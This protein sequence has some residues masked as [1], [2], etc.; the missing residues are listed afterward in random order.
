MLLLLTRSSLQWV[1]AKLP[2]RPISVLRETTALGSARSGWTLVW[3]PA[4]ASEDPKPAVF[5]SQGSVR[6]S[7]GQW[8]PLWNQ[9]CS[10]FNKYCGGD[11]A[12]ITAQ[13]V[14]GHIS[15]W[16]R[17]TVRSQSW[18]T[19]RMLAETVHE[20][21]VLTSRNL[22]GIALCKIWSQENP[23]SPSKYEAPKT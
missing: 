18:K 12:L 2:A 21:E 10:P 1:R 9:P 5:A 23:P 14:W 4:E 8:S 7:Q 20:C 19:V 3:P 13:D 16:T 6:T 22:W 17:L 11:I 15:L